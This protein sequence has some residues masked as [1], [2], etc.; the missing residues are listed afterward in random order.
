MSLRRSLA[1]ALVTALALPGL[2]TA[3][4]NAPPGNSGVDQYF[5]SVPGATGNQR[6]GAGGK[7]LPKSTQRALKRQGADGKALAQAIAVT[8]R[9]AASRDRSAQE[10]S[11][12][13]VLSPPSRIGA[14]AK[15][16][17][18]DTGGVGTGL[19]LPGLMV[20]SALG[21]VGFMLARRM[22]G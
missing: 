21:A 11:D 2:A 20:L 13:H 1:A 6:P 16:L 17:I 10:G 4:S 15:P 18:G 14:V 7:A 5:E 22:R 3:E 12:D 9:P 8:Q 19:L